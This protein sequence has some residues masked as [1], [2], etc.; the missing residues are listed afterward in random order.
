ML[1]DNGFSQ[2]VNVA[3]HF[4]GGHIDHV[5]S[6]HDPQLFNVKVNLYSPFYL[7]SD[8]DAICVTIT[9]PPKRAPQKLRKNKPRNK[10]NISIIK[11]FILLIIFQVCSCSDIKHL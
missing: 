2:L 6:N 1:E 9:K 5:Y 3:T 4:R 11:M 8:H 10:G 7:A